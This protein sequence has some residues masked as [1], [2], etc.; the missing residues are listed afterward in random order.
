MLKLKA[1]PKGE[2]APITLSVIV[3]LY[4]ETEV[5]PALHQRLTQVLDAMPERCEIVFVDDGSKDGSHQMAQNLPRSSSEHL[6][7]S[8]S[9]NFGKEAAMSA[10]LA[11]ARGQAVILLDADLQDPPELIP[12]MLAKWRE[13]YDVVNMQRRRRLGES[14]FKR[15]SAAAY[16]RILN[17]LSEMPIPEN[18]GDFRLLS[19][20]VVDQL[21]ALPERSRY[22]KG[23]FAWP[24]FK[25]ITLQF[26]RD[27]REAGDTKWNYP[28]LV[29]LAMDGITSFS[30]RPL[31]LATWTGLTIALGAFLYGGWVVAKTLLWGE[32]V[33]GYPSLMVAVLALGGVQLVAMG[34]LGEYLGRVYIETKGRPNYLVAEV[35]ER[36]RQVLRQVQEA[37]G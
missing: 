10:G 7:L 19:R 33:A 1:L 23:L 6:C 16:Y 28:K 27:P 37:Q 21:N 12:D 35:I 11:Y 24:G 22:M 34:L 4:N 5:L 36:P 29:G 30:I 2:I 32:T 26:D 14:W 8:L 25:Q 17:W 3:P 9:R 18:V 20:Q 13:G 31:R 15:T